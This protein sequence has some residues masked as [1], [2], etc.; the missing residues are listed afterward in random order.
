MT[1]P[2]GELPYQLTEV[3]VV[4]T[5]RRWGWVAFVVDDQDG[6]T[7]VRWTQH[8][9]SPYRCD[10]H[11][12]QQT[13]TCPCAALARRA[14]RARVN[15][16]AAAPP[17]EPPQGSPGRLS[18]G[19]PSKSRTWGQYGNTSRAEQHG[20]SQSRGGGRSPS[21]APGGHR[22]RGRSFAVR[23]AENPLRLGAVVLALTAW[24]RAVVPAEAVRHGGAPA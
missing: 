9:H 24:L 4:G 20:L 2:R 17:G 1:T 8:R 15:G 16:A 12:A 11:G 18:R 22:P 23:R 19:I 21:A 13:P 3:R 14:V 7:R 10:V 5:P 6:E